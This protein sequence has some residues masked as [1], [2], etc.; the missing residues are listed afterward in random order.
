MNELYPIQRGAY[1]KPPFLIDFNV[2]EAFKFPCWPNYDP[3]RRIQ[4]PVAWVV[5]LAKALAT[6]RARQFI[7]SPTF[8]I[9]ESLKDAIWKYQNLY[10]AQRRDCVNDVWPF[11]NWRIAEGRAPTP[12]GTTND[13]LSLMG[14]GKAKPIVPV[15]RR[16]IP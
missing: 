7:L 11:D 15:K 10:N 2:H 13:L 9:G 6:F 4:E 16:I 5:N 14:I 3:R 12:T 8:E 1:H